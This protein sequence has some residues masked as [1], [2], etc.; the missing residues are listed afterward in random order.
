M[1]DSLMRKHRRG[2]SWRRH[3]ANADDNSGGILFYE[4]PVVVPQVMHFKHVPLRTI[5]N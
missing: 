5:V 4:H 1:G 3:V 2:L